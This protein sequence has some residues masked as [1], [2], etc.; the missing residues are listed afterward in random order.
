MCWGSG[1]NHVC[2]RFVKISPW[3][4]SEEKNENVNFHGGANDSQ[5]IWF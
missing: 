4:T 5:L 3:R 2:K 1:R